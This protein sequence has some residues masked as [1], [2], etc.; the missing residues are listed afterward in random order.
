M[1]LLKR[2]FA[3]LRGKRL[4]G[5]FPVL[6]CALLQPRFGIAAGPP[7]PAESVL[8]LYSS[9]TAYGISLKDTFKNA[10]LAVTP[11][12][13]ITEV[14]YAATDIGIYT[15]LVAQ[16][17]QTSLSSWCQVYDLRFR[18]DKNNIAYTGPNQNDVITFAG[19]N[20]D[21]ALFT[22]YLNANGHLFLQGEHHDFYIRDQNL[23]AFINAVATVPINTA[24][25]AQQYAD[26]NSMNTGVI[27][28]FSSFNGF[29]T[30][31]N[32]LVGGT[33]NAGFPGG[34][35]RAY[36]GSGH[37]IGADFTSQYNSTGTNQANTAY[38][39]M[40]NDLTTNGRMVVNFETNAYQNPQPA[41]TPASVAIEWIQNVYQLLSGCYRYSLT[42]AFVP[43]TL[44]VGDP[45]TFT[46][47]YSNSG[48]TNLTNVPLWDTLPSCLTYSSDSLGGA[49][50]SGQVYSWVIPSINAGTSACITVHFTV[51]GFACP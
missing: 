23:F 5:A 9:A 46:L 4:F 24:S 11:A 21:T 40:S 51:N 16:T 25:T 45:G 30:N 36:A 41:G 34:L 48:S 8:L 17:G 42:K 20:N 39:W 47:C 19:A 37:P 27:G 28:G 29:N 22:N 31:W 50:N 49:S 33:I 44:C 26:V 1:G 2:S 10:L 12:P 13:T 7:N 18:E 38:A 32:N 3:F 15:Q 43:T 14:A 6:L 35:E